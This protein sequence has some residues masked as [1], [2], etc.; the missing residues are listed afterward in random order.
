M[1]NLHKILFLIT[2]ILLFQGNVFGSSYTLS[3]E[4]NNN[5]TVNADTA[6]VDSD[7][8]IESTGNLIFPDGTVVIFNG[9]YKITVNG[10]LTATGTLVQ[11]ILFTAQNKDIGWG[12]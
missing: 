2:T 4:Y 1:K 6:Y 7:V 3:P 9:N 10:T 11:G 12:G 8:T 5:Y